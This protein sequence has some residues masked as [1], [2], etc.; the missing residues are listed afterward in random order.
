MLDIDLIFSGVSSFLSWLDTLYISQGFSLLDFMINIFVF[1]VLV[2]VI[3]P[4]F[5]GEVNSYE[6]DWNHNRLLFLCHVTGD[7][8]Y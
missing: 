5:N 6:K 7:F 1:G 8:L 2:G 4:W 3:L